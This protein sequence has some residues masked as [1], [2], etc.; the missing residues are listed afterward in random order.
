MKYKII[1]GTALNCQKR[2]NQWRH[3]YDLNIL[4]M[5]TNGNSIVIL[6][7]RTKKREM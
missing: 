3:G 2:L 6:L 4:A 1:T 5:S 7:T